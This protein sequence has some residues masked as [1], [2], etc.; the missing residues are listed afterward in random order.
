MSEPL[1]LRDV[2]NGIAGLLSAAGMRNV[3]P[4]PVDAVTPPAVIVG[5]PSEL[6][7]DMHFAGDLDGMTV[8][9][10][11]VVGKTST[12]ASWSAISAVVSGTSGVKT[13]VDGIHDFGNLRL[14]GGSI[15]WVTIEAIPYLSVKYEVDVI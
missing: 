3:F 13:A 12:N 14:T 5:A 9:I 11:F 15:E 10:W 4:W 6:T 7:F 2:M 1:V 8:P